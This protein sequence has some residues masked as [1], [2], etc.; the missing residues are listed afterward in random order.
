MPENRP[1]DILLNTY[2]LERLLGQGAFGEVYLAQHMQLNVD[3]AIKIL[4]RESLG[5]GST[6]YSQARER[7]LTEARLGAQLK[8]PNLV[9]V[10]DFQDSREMLLLVMEYCPGGNL[11]EWS[12]R[13]KQGK[14]A[15]TLQ[16]VLTTL[17]SVASG[18]SALHT[19]DIVHRDLKPSNILFDKIQNA[20]VADLGLAQMPGG[21]SQRSVLGSQALQHPGTP[22]YMSPEQQNSNDYLSP[23]SDVYALGLVIFELL[24]GK[25]YKNQRPGT[26]AA[27]LR[28]G[29]P[30]WLDQL[31]MRMLEKEP[32]KR[33]WNGREVLREIEAGLTNQKMGVE[34]QRLQKEAEE[35]GQQKTGPL[36]TGLQQPESGPNALFENPGSLQAERIEVESVNPEKI[37]LAHGEPV[38]PP[39]NP[40]GEKLPPPKI[41]QRPGRNAV[42]GL[43]WKMGAILA[44]GS[45][46]ALLGVGFWLSSRLAAP[47]PTRIPSQMPAILP[48]LTPELKTIKTQVSEKDGMKL[49][50]V[51]AGEFQMGSENGGADEKPAHKVYLDAFWIDQTE[52]TNEDYAGCVKSGVCKASYCQGDARI[53]SKTQPI[54]CVDWNQAK[55]YCEW[56]GRT[57]PTEAQ[58]EKA[59]RGTDGRAYPWGNQPPA[60]N[61][62]NVADK[63][64]A[65][66]WAD[67]NI[68]DGYIFSAPVGSYPEGVSPYGALD[69]AG[70]VFEWVADWYGETYYGNAPNR[71]PT[72]PDSGQFRVLRGGS[73]STG[74][75]VARSAYRSI[76]LMPA[77]YDIIF[78][79]RCAVNGTQ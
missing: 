22:A 3:R 8:T 36:E 5:V 45:L 29:T 76:F 10:Y 69:M 60:G 61:L 46:V 67:K 49:M 63:N 54:V 50:Y 57:L 27:S 7:F 73:W 31:L 55:T 35:K 37:N 14:K 68:D 19:R 58:W 65:Y 33:P 13:Q 28:V 9:E 79:F 26:S 23:A 15:P 53:N 62:L 52:V 44:G 78:G 77:N 18:L 41:N 1:G 71:N 48:T 6:I 32:E 39:A 43:V 16:T 11:L 40:F 56:A 12:S 20:K 2:Q 59:A 75:D 42:V 66:D 17:V 47:V 64:T 25:N 70:N 38:S 34:R 72:G 24:T 30:A 4:K 51:P 74:V 21:L